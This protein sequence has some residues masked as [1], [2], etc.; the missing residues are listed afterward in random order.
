MDLTSQENFLHAS[1]VHDSVD[2][3]PP[4]TNCIVDPS[5]VIFFFIFFLII[6][7]T[8]LS[9]LSVVPAVGIPGTHPAVVAQV[10]RSRPA[11]LARLRGGTRCRLRPWQ[12]GGETPPPGSTVGESRWFYAELRW[13]GPS[14]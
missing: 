11:E 6:I 9:S 4:L 5:R 3:L 13:R 8:I 10:R 14:F 1:G 2:L 7:I 12:R